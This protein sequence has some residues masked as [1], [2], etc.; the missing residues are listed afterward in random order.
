MTAL[1][2]IKKLSVHY[3]AKGGTV[4][5]VTNADLTINEGEIVRIGTENGDYLGRATS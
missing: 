2:E 1:L 5:A 3:P 4:K